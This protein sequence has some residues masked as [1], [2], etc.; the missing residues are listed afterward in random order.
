MS[1][2]FNQMF[3]ATVEEVVGA[4]IYAKNRPYQ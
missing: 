4:N 1:G 3:P 2:D